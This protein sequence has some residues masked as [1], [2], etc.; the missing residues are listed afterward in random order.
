MVPDSDPRGALN[1]RIDALTSNLC[2]RVDELKES[3]ILELDRFRTAYACDIRK[4]TEEFEIR[5]DEYN[6]EHLQ[7]IIE[8][9]EQISYLRELVSSQ[10]LMMEDNLGYTRELEQKLSA[11]FIKTSGVL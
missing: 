3:H 2:K 1:A 10:R 9:E 11:L 6:R 8:L 7:R 5:W 4:L